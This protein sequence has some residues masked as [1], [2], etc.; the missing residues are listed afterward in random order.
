[1]AARKCTEQKRGG[2][3]RILIWSEKNDP[4]TRPRGV[5]ALHLSEGR[6]EGVVGSVR[7]WRWESGYMRGPF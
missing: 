5:P 2:A 7:A 6:E 1:M 4:R 3:H